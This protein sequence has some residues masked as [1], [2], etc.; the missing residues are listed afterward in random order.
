MKVSYYSLGFPAQ[1][2][3]A[4]CFYLF[5]SHLFHQLVKGIYTESLH[6]RKCKLILVARSIPKCTHNM[7][8]LPLNY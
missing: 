1:L 8:L 6:L 3:S 7:R 2:F 4:L 5:L